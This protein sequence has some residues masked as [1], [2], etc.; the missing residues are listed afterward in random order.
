MPIGPTIRRLLDGQP[1][2]VHALTEAYRGFFVD[3]DAVVSAIPLEQP[4]ATFLNI[5]TGDGALLNALRDRHPELRVTTTDIHDHQGWLLR[6]DVRESL[7]IQVHTPEQ[8]AASGFGGQFDVVFMSD[9]LHHVPPADRAETLRAAFAACR[10]GGRVVIKDIEERGIKARLSLLSDVYLTGDK[11]TRLIGE[12]ALR[13]L[14]EGTQ[15]DVKVASSDLI[16]RDF[17]NY[18]VVATLAP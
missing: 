10:P 4:N 9:V 6:P 1:K 15:P 18:L 13:A 14:I 2:L 8:I 12:A 3:L 11:H 16:A 7:D 5:G 17:P